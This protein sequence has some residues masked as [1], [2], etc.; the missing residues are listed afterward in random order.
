MDLLPETP[1]ADNARDKFWRKAIAEAGKRLKFLPERVMEKQ[2][3]YAAGTMSEAYRIGAEEA[4]E[5]IIRRLI[6][7]QG[8]LTA[9]PAP[10]VAEKP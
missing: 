1:M 2:L 7:L 5:E 9:A 6:V 10:T 4:Q 8:K 3:D